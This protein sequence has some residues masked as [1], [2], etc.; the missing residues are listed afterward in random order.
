MAASDP[1][2]DLLQGR[3]MVTRDAAMTASMMI[4]QISLFFLILSPL[5]P[6]SFINA[7]KQGGVIR[8]VKR[9]GLIISR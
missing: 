6:D 8:P 4:V 9:Y 1:L 3:N 7:R 5:F 2:R